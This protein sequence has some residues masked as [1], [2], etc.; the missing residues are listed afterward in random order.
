MQP[1]PL[2]ATNLGQAPA[3][4][5]GSC[6]GAPRGLLVRLRPWAGRSISGFHLSDKQELAPKDEIAR[7]YRRRWVSTVDFIKMCVKG[8]AISAAITGRS[9]VYGL[10]RSLTLPHLDAVQL[11]TGGG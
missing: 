10:G 8:F 11:T 9:A 2:R 6:F 4:A 1:I 5:P 3:I 7:P